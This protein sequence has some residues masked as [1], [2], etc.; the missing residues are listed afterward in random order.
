M[1]NPQNKQKPDTQNTFKQNRSKQNKVRRQKAFKQGRRAEAYAR[2]VLCA[3]G[4]RLL[5][6]NFRH[7]LDEV[8]LILRR[9]RLLVFVEVKFRA[10]SD[11]SAYAVSPAHWRCISAG[12]PGF[13]ARHPYYADHGWRF[14][15]FVVVAMGPTS[16]RKISGALEPTRNFGESVGRGSHAR[17]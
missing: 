8:D 1:K 6:R 15:L 11:A 17:P 5:V 9:G 3:K 2:W 13:V 4:Y 16:T 10:D 14:N 7:P 12:A